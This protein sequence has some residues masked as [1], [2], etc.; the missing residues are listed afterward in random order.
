[1][2]FKLAWRNIR[3]NLR[4]YS[5]YFFT[6]II[7]VV[8][9]Y[10]FN[11]IPYQELLKPYSSTN[12]T[13]PGTIQMV[14][15]VL[16]YILMGI[17]ACL[18]IYANRYMIR[19]RA[20]EFSVYLTLGMGK[21]KIAKILF[22]ENLLLTTFAFG[23][24]ILIGGVS[25]YLLSLFTNRLFE[26]SAVPIH[27]HFIFS[28][29]SAFLT[30]ILFF[31]MIFLLYLANL[32][33]IKK[34]SVI[35]W[36][37]KDQKVKVKKRLSPW[38]Y[39]SI[40]LL[41][42][43]SFSFA[44]YLAYQLVGPIF[45]I[46]KLTGSIVLGIVGIFLFFYGFS[47]LFSVIIKRL[48]HLYYRGLNPYFIEKLDQSFKETFISMSFTCL[49]LF[50]SISMLI[51]GVSLSKSFTEGAKLCSQYDLTAIDYGDEAKKY[52]LSPNLDIDHYVSNYN[53]I[54][55]YKNIGPTFTNFIDE[56]S[57][58]KDLLKNVYSFHAAEKVPLIPLSSYHSYQK[59]KGEKE[60][61]LSSD[62][63]LMV[64][65]QEEV[66][67]LMKKNAV[68]ML[69]K[70]ELHNKDLRYHCEPLYNC[71]GLAGGEVLCLVVPD[72]YVKN[73]TVT[74]SY[75]NFN[76]PSMK[77]QDAMVDRLSNLC[78]KDYQKIDKNGDIIDDYSPFYYISHQGVVDSNYTFGL[79][80]AYIGIFIGLVLLICG[81]VILSIQQLMRND[82]VK[83]DYQVLKQIGSSEKQRR[84]TLFVTI[85]IYFLVPA[86]LAV[87]QSLYVLPLLNFISVLFGRGI[88]IYS[89]FFKIL[90]VFLLLYGV[91]FFITYS[92]SKEKIE[93]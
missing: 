54:Q 60:T 58:K 22:L 93:E 29:S 46:S 11:A 79:T 53:Y 35:A 76:F 57:A 19:Q 70:K 68:I 36:M 75:F 61:K 43:A 77:K 89:Y 73:K 10:S 2:S 16:S 69:N 38:I 31:F 78:A 67:K 25:S 6:L 17:F 62:E 86:V 14:M 23:L 65:M 24:G 74:I 87:Y 56:G 81:L 72:Q 92:T 44:D 71:E 88:G 85:M 34:D 7:G 47:H 48:P 55:L 39:G 33:E 66:G 9:I 52:V 26:T 64:G 82:Q 15:K 84:H 51:G 27:F 80:A 91:Y 63:Y 21:R 5:I 8:L 40:G 3:K 20:Q 90:I 45:S 1:M 37:K 30:G 32:Y 4:Q 13:G 18:L 28:K 59:S 50:V 12:V 41:G 83:K 49:L 42:I